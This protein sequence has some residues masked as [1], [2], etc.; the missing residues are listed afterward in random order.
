MRIMRKIVF[1]IL[2][3]LIYVL[4]NLL[5]DGYIR[6]YRNQYFVG[7]YDIFP[8]SDSYDYINLGRSIGADSFNWKV[9]EEYKGLNMGMAGKSLKTDLM[10][11]NFYGNLV[12]ENTLIIIPIT[13][14]FFC[15]DEMPYTPIE[16]IYNYDFPLFGMVQTNASIGYFLR[17]QGYINRPTRNNS[18]PSDYQPKSLY[19]PDICD[20]SNLNLYIELIKQMQSITTNIVLI[21]TPHY[22][23]F[24][25]K[26]EN[27][28]FVWFYE[29]VN[30]LVEETKVKFIDYS[31]LEELQ[32]KDY[33]HDFTHL[34][35]R[36]RDIF[37]KFFVDDRE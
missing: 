37:T 6:N 20:N 22:V 17:S 13:F 25:D 21:I 35:Q 1:T 14:S 8:I 18:I 31:D 19:E 33:F 5:L 26:K 28:E 4:A 16:T 27:D 36:G 29:N 12:S 32:N 30:Y 7:E 23:E 34:N 10:L 9:N 3:L 15:S 2:V 11:L 24:V